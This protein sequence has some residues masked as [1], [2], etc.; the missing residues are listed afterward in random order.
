MD[1]FRVLAGMVASAVGA[2]VGLNRASLQLHQNTPKL[3][4]ARLY[5][6]TTAAPARRPPTR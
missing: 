3:L 2:I 5:D 1:P 4:I 6:S